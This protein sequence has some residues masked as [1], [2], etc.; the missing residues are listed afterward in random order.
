MLDDEKEQNTVILREYNPDSRVFVN[1]FRIEEEN[2]WKDVGKIVKANPSLVDPSFSESL[3]FVLDVF[4]R[5][6]A[7]IFLPTTF[8]P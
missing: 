6:A 7:F 5:K 4:S 2:E 8:S 1:W 3:F